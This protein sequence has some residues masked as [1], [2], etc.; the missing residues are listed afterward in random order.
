MS[1]ITAAQWV[2][3]GF[4]APFPKKYTLDDSEYERIAAL[5]KLQLNDAADDLKEAQENGAHDDLQDA[6][7][8]ET[9]QGEEKKSLGID[10]DLK[11]YDLEHYDDDDGDGISGHDQD[12]SGDEEQGQSMAMFGNIKSLAYY[13]SNEDDPY[14]TLKTDEQE[15]DQDREDLQILTT[16]NL[17][18]SAKVEDE[19]A[20]LEQS[21][22]VSNGSMCR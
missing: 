9:G 11:E 14:I 5:A 17:I 7:D 16:D 15:E 3:R 20:Q 19:L 4:A 2:P 6:M 22:F 1:M 12:V 13:E 8:V 18:L 10:D 21:P